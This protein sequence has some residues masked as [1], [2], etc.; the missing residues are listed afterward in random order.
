[1]THKIA[2]APRTLQQTAAAIARVICPTDNVQRAR[3]ADL[4]SDELLQAFNSGALRMIHRETFRPIPPEGAF[5]ILV[6]L[7]SGALSIQEANRWLSE[8]G[9]PIVL[10]DRHFAATLTARRRSAYDDETRAEAH[11]LAN[12]FANAEFLKSGCIPPVV[13][14]AIGIRGALNRRFGKNWSAPTIARHCI[15]SWKFQV[16]SSTA[17]KPQEEI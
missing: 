15:D 11:R 7:R 17:Q 2:H 12:E 16:F 8:T 5:G 14:V 3:L 4:W 1:M 9:N 10:S 13:E 6:A